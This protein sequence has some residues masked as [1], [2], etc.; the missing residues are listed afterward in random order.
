[1]AGFP[2]KADQTK[3]LDDSYRGHQINHNQLYM[4]EATRQAIL[5]AD[6]VMPAKIR[7]ESYLAF[8]VSTT[9]N[10]PPTLVAR[11]K[12]G[13]PEAQKLVSEAEANGAVVEYTLREEFE[14][15]YEKAVIGEPLDEELYGEAKMLQHMVRE[16][17]GR[18]V[19]EGEKRGELTP[20]RSPG[21]QKQ[22]R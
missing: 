5:T 15:L 9:P 18:L 21:R 22:K 13:G 14:S 2:P 19:A 4:D 1:M 16:K 3:Q 10:E 7:V 17:V 12:M 11:G 20:F 6:I 8:K